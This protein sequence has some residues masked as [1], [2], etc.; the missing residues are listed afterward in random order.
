[1]SCMSDFNAK[2]KWFL[3]TLSRMEAL[4]MQEFSS[5]DQTPLENQNEGHPPNE[6][7]QSTQEQP[8][9]SRQKR[10]QKGR[11][12]AKQQTNFKKGAQNR[13]S[14]WK[15]M[16][17]VLKVLWKFCSTAYDIASD[18]LQGKQALLLIFPKLSTCSLKWKTPVTIITVQHFNSRC[19][20]YQLAHGSF[21]T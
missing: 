8:G 16:T 7:S 21:C 12:C 3:F 6:N 14:V 13:P 11:D 10:R 5:E 20:I 4:E 2:M 1:M 19:A 17:S 15:L 18:F 9:G